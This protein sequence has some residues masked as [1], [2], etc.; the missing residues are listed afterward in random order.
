MLKTNKWILYVKEREPFDREP[1]FAAI[2]FFQVKTFKGLPKI[3]CIYCT[4]TAYIICMHA[5]KFMYYVCR[6]GVGYHLTLV[7]GP[8]CDTRQLCELI[9]STVPGSELASDVSAELTFL[10]PF[11]S[12]QH[13]PT[14]LD[15]LERESTSSTTLTSSHPP[16]I[17]THWAPLA[18]LSHP[19]TLTGYTHTEHL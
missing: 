3:Q 2:L 10:L 14:L 1:H 15:T 4:C 18:Q 12:S 17:H 5:C 16:W 8:S 11:T 19:H 7:K 13:F 9:T 6:Y